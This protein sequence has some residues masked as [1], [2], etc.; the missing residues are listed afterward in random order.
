[1]TD[2]IN[3]TTTMLYRLAR[4]LWVSSLYANNDKLF[5]EMKD[6]KIGDLVIEI[7]TPNLKTSSSKKTIDAI[8][9]LQHYDG[10]SLYVI[11]RLANNKIITWSNAEFV[12]VPNDITTII[13]E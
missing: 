7:T 13:R 12:K 1:M 10:N 3:D 5:E 2:H 6:I 4:K 9:Y 8:G 11:K